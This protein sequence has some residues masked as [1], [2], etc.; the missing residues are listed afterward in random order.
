MMPG[1]G[2]LAENEMMQKHA[3]FHALRV[4][5]P[6]PLEVTS[7][8]DDKHDKHRHHGMLSLLPGSHFPCLFGPVPTHASSSQEARSKTTS[9]A[10]FTP[11]GTK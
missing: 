3:E 4:G 2:D 6:L 10:F 5:L 9:S 8:H 11:P 1:G 7:V